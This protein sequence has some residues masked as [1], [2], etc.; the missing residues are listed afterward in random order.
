M[1]NLPLD[2]VEQSFRRVKMEVNAKNIPSNK[3]ICT[4]CVTELQNDRLVCKRQ[5]TSLRAPFHVSRTRSVAD[6]FAYPR[7]IPRQ[8][9]RHVPEDLCRC[10]RRGARRPHR[11]C[12]H[13]SADWCH[14]PGR[15]GSVAGRPDLQRGH[16]FRHRHL[17][18]A[19][20]L[21]VRQAGLPDRRRWRTDAV[22]VHGLGVHASAEEPGPAG[23]GLEKHTHFL[24]Q[25]IR[26]LGKAAF[27]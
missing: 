9:S 19:G 11:R 10:R 25:P 7:Y 21:P 20:T 12:C 27:T 3:K 13:R 1:C 16:R 23:P 8:T 18:H 6:V 2:L 15:A 14:L 5:E 22:G 24:H 17:C 26:L 4:K